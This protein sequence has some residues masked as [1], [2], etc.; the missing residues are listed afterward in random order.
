[1]V[2]IGVFGSYVK[3]RKASDIDILIEFEKTR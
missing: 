3:G 2:I 1:M